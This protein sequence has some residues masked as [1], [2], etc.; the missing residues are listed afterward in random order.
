MEFHYL[1]RGIIQVDGKV[2]LTHKKGADHTYLPGG[3]IDLGESAKSALARE[4]KEEIGMEA[5]V[6][7]FVGAVEHVWTEDGADNH[8]I[9]LVF[10]VDVPGL[11]S[12][13]DPS[14][15]EPDLEF[16][17]SEVSD[18]K[19]H[20]LQPYPLIECLAN[21]KRGYRGYWGSSIKGGR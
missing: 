21:L 4:I 10:E 15:L 17:W 12:A 5:R 6:K 14:S 3:H 9:N 20:N 1:V 7:G 16:I 2:L 19:S 8:E 18:L 13:A 11:E